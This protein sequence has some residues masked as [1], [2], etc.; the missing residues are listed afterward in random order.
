MPHDFNSVTETFCKSRSCSA[1]TSSLAK[2]NAP[3]GAK[4]LSI[5]V[6]E[7]KGGMPVRPPKHTDASFGAVI[8]G[9]AVDDCGSII[10]NGVPHPVDAWGPLTVA[11]VRSS[12]VTAGS[13]AAAPQLAAAG[14]RLAA[15]AVLESIRAVL[16]AIE[17]EAETGQE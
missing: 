6:Y 2:L 11:L 10:I 4:M 5:T 14:R 12:L 9:V 1:Q 16:P 15:K 3:A 13:S 7:S 17:R 8:G